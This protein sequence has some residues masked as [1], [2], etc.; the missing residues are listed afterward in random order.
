MI[1]LFVVFKFKVRG[2]VFQV[3]VL[4][5]GQD[6]VLAMAY[7]SGVQGIV[8]LQHHLSQ[9]RPSEFDE[10]RRWD[11]PLAV[12]LEKPR[13]RFCE[14]LRQPSFYLRQQ[15]RHADCHQGKQPFR[16]KS[17]E[18]FWFSVCLTARTTT[19]VQF[20]GPTFN[21]SN[22]VM[23]CSSSIFFLLLWFT[24]SRHFCKKKVVLPPL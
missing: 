7:L 13:L 18:W 24:I 3:S 9:V 14:P 6:L 15:P 23:L 19:R 10:E 22:R 2:F 21:W 11:R 1:S 4:L 20:I 17:L 12:A 5:R 16:V 8:G